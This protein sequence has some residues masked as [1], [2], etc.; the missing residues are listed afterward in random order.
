MTAGQR[1]RKDAGAPRLFTVAEANALLPEAR[2]AVATMRRELGLLR[3]LAPR[4]GFTLPVDVR[5]PFGDAAVP[6]AY[7]GALRRL[8]EAHEGLRE[9]GVW[10]KDPQAG[11]VDF[12]TLDGTRL[13]LLCW[14]DGEDSI[15][16]F[17][18]LHSGFGGR[19]PLGDL[20]R[21]SE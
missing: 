7:A 12:P 15:G 18:D 17:H 2:I 4:L 5:L 20:G 11:L 6:V 1:P 9:R 8:F 21:P 16:W 10:V 13:V 3:G 14:R 19:R